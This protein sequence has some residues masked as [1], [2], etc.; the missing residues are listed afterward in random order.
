MDCPDIPLKD[1]LS[2]RY[3]TEEVLRGEG[4]DVPPVQVQFHSDHA[5]TLLLAPGSFSPSPPPFSGLDLRG[6]VLGGRL[7]PQRRRRQKGLP[8]PVGVLGRL[9][10]PPAGGRRIADV[11]AGEVAH[12]QP[13]EPAP[14]VAKR[15][16]VVGNLGGLLQGGSQQLSPPVGSPNLPRLHDKVSYR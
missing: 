5:C 8:G 14:G 4:G 9:R 2:F 1:S 6:G 16:K 12:S 15:L 10:R 13:V 7:R 3:W 11:G